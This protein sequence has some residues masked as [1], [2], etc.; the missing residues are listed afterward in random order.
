M[1]TYIYTDQHSDLQ[2]NSAQR[3]RVSDNLLWTLLI[4]IGEFE[5]IKLY[6]DKYTLLSK[7][8]F[9]FRFNNK[10]KLL[11]TYANKYISIVTYSTHWPSSSRG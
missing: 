8:V 4:N 7:Y 2:T 3:D 10:L 5:Y 1:H 9:S 11:N 6:F